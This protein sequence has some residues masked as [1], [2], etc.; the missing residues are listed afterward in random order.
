[1]VVLKP[2]DIVVLLKLS[3][4]P[5]D[6]SYA[7]LAGAL[8]MS[9]SEVHAAIRRAAESG[10]FN[11]VTRAPI[12]SA[13]LELLLHGLRYVFP[14]VRGAITRGIPT[15]YAAPPLSNLMVADGDPPP[16]WPDPEG[17]VRGEELRPL[18][19]SVPAAA[20]R[21]ERLYHLLAL[22]DA[23][24]AGRARERALASEELTKRLS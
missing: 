12:R 14:P 23:V 19:P 18:Y 22:V 24:R 21:D 6:W 17:D 9:S 10:L 3:V 2:Q 11:P 16:V 15:A 5:R 8:G 7:A 1:M 13:L 4:G 20:R